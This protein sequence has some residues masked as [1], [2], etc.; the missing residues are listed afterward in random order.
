MTFQNANSILISADGG[1]HLLDGAVIRGAGLAKFYSGAQVTVRSVTHIVNGQDNGMSLSGSGDVYLYGN[2]DWGGGSWTGGSTT[3]LWVK[4]N[5]TLRTY[6][7]TLGRYLT[8]EGTVRWTLGDINVTDGATV[9]TTPCSR[10][11][12]TPE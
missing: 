1:S 12:V 10:S 3:K 2:L 5:A 8:N 6:G 9:T 4:P 7:G 11:G